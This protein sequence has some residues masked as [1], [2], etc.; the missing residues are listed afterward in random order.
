MSDFADLSR[1]ERQIMSVV[2]AANGA[3]VMEVQRKLPDPPTDMAVRRMMHILEEKGYLSRRKRGRGYVYIPTQPKKGAG[4]RAL[5]HVIDTFF[6][7]ALD[8]ALA[9]HLGKREATVTREQLDRMR[10]LIDEAR[11]EGR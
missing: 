5:Q 8:S 9:A 11:K 7:G 2:Y 10:R 6:E 3:T 1:R 4:L